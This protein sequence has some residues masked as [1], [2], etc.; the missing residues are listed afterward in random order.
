MLD[1]LSGGRLEVGFAR[2]F[3]PHE[4]RAFRRFARRVDRPLQRRARA[5]RV[6]F[7]AAKTS[8]H[9]GQFNS[10]DNITTL[11]AADAEAAAE[12]LGRRDH[13]QRDVRIRRD[14][15]AFDHGDPDGGRQTR[16]LSRRLSQ[17]VPRGRSSRETVKSCSPFTCSS[18][19]TASGRDASPARRSTRTSARSS[20]RRSSGPRG[21]RPRIIR[22][23]TR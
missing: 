5:D 11:S 19:P 10:F 15:G 3:L 7:V 6:A 13:D 21:R 14:A 1:G 23:T 2:A 9:H 12:I 17:R 22:A 16:G 8:P 4:F 20:P 18:M